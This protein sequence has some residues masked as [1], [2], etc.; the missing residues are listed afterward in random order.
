MRSEVFTAGS[1]ER[2][3]VECNLKVAFKFKTVRGH[4]QIFIKNNES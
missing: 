1:E 2:R 4:N 3:E